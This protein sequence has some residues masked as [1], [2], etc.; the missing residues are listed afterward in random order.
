MLRANIKKTPRYI[1]EKLDYLHSL[2]Q[3]VKK[4][5][6]D[7]ATYIRDKQLQR[8][9]ITLAQ[10]S[11]QYAC[12]LSSMIKTLGGEMIQ[13][14]DYAK[15]VRQPEPTNNGNVLEYE[16]EILSICAACEKKMISAYREILNEP[17]LYDGV[18]NLIRSQFNG[19]LCAFLQVKLLN[20]SLQAHH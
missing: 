5:Y 12:E 13:S 1:L 15:I 20:N 10:E 16:K 8:T 4:K 18:R 3:E 14:G 7:V 9:V 19:V 2:L 11:N 17:Y 6:E